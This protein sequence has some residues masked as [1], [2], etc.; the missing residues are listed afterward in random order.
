MP[1][2]SHT[3]GAHDREKAWTAPRAVIGQP[4]GSG[5]EPQ[6]IEV[7]TDVQWSTNVYHSVEDPSSPWALLSPWGGMPQM[8]MP[9]DAAGLQGACSADFSV[10]PPPLPCFGLGHDAM[11]ATA[12]GA[13]PLKEGVPCG[14]PPPTAPSF[15]SFGHPFHCAKPCKYFSRA[16]GCKDGRNCDRCH[17]CSWHRRDAQPPATGWANVNSRSRN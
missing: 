1:T 17:L 12:E 3:Q 10:P 11:L 9:L 15:G 7:Q 13:T 5:G 2:Q 4:Q 8:A 14:G 16:R 6:W